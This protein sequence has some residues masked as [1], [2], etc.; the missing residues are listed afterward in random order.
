M[1]C[2][3]INEVSGILIAVLNFKWVDQS[4]IGIHLI[5]KEKMS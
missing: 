5:W 3:P 1:I 4:Q 2:N